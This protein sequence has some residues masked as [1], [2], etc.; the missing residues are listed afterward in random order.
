MKILIHSTT[1]DGEPLETD[2]IALEGKNCA[3]LVEIM[4]GQTPF[5]IEA[6]PRD[7]MPGVLG[8]IEPDRKLQLPEDPEAA[9]TTIRSAPASSSAPIT[10]PSTTPI[11]CSADWVCRAMPRWTA[12]CYSGW[13]IALHPTELSTAEASAKP[14][15]CVAAK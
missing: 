3:E 9:A 5:T 4:K 1:L 13:P 11:I 6:T 12:S 2:G 8:R 7:Y 14:C 15:S 10:A